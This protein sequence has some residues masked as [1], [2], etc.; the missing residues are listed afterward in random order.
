MQ[1]FLKT[2][3]L[4]FLLVVPVSLFLF[5]RIFGEN[6]FDLPYFH[7]VT[8]PGG[9]VV[10]HGADTV[11]YRVAGFGLGEAD[12]KPGGDDFFEN[13]FTLVVAPSDACSDSLVRPLNY[14]QRYW[15]LHGGDFPQLQLA[16]LSAGPADSVIS[17]LQHR[18]FPV[19]FTVFTGDSLVVR[20]TAEGVLKMGEKP[21]REK[22]F[23]AN[24]RLILVDDKRYIR[25]YYDL[26][27]EE[28][29]DRMTA[30]LRII[31]QNYQNE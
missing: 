19:P 28:E 26:G 8:G 10:M 9:Q 7:P 27:T 13:R 15:A 20:R 23:F 17:C 1:R 31:Q 6:H 22:T 25:G 16:V 12:G 2:G 29:A 24:Q 3:L 21:G 5:L 14:L 11:Y 18:E 30:E 4:L